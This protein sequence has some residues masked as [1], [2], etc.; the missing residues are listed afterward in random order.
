MTYRR[1]EGHDVLW[2]T[3]VEKWGFELQLMATAEELLELAAELIR[4]THRPWRSRPVNLALETA[5]VHLM[6]AQLDYAMVVT[7]DNAWWERVDRAIQREIEKLEV[8]MEIVPD[9][10]AHSWYL[11]GPK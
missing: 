1:L 9:P 2:R 11:E 4:F 7:H 6:L 8:K 3:A 5:Q 10:L